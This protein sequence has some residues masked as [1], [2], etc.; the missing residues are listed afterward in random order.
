LENDKKLDLRFKEG[1]TFTLNLG[2][3]QDDLG[4]KPRARPTSNSN[5]NILLPPPPGA[6]RQNQ[7]ITL[8]KPNSMQSTSQ[9]KTNQSNVDLL[10][11]LDTGR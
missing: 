6:S 3:K 1:Q 5:M 4:A 7:P 9:P 2:K 8:S 11:D 10:L